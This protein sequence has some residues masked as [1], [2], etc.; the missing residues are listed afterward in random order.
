[1]SNIAF[2]F[3]HKKAIEVILYLAQNITVHNVY[4]ICKLLYLADKISL[5]NYGRFI[6]GE[7][8]V[9]MKEGSTPSNTYDLMKSIRKQPTDDL[10]IEDN[11]VI[12]LRQADLDYLSKSDLECL[13][14]VIDKYSKPK[15]W[16]G[17]KNACHD[18]AWQ[19]AWDA[20]GSAKSYP[21]TIE[22]IAEILQDSDNLIDYLSNSR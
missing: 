14:L 1:M 2:T 8:Y 13:D 6:F 21:I 19:K 10:K 3:N 7:S 15:D 4:G 17:R 11:N 12:P 18:S 22:S 5:E 20:K 16:T 9:A